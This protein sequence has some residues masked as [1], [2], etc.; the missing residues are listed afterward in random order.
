LYKTLTDHW[1]EGPEGLQKASPLPAGCMIDPGYLLVVK[2][3]PRKEPSA[4]RRNDETKEKTPDVDW[5]TTCLATVKQLCEQC[6]AGA[7]AGK[8][9]DQLPDLPLEL[10][11]N[12]QVV[13]AYYGDLAGDARRM[14]APVDPIKVHYIRMEE[15]NRYA[16][17]VGAY[18]RQL[19]TDRSLTTG[20]W[21]DY[22]RASGGGVQQSIDVIINRTNPPAPPPSD[23][24]QPAPAAES[25]DQ[26]EPLVIEV[27][28]VE[29]KAPQRV[30]EAKSPYR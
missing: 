17:V 12:A 11:P 13:S 4:T 21:L 10:H 19:R 3:L 15:T 29:T 18:K 20:V 27:L 7:V 24:G 6:R 9:A 2:A 1:K 8:T 14:K 26:T 30:I 16:I 28:A 5:M 23:S 22:V 25:A